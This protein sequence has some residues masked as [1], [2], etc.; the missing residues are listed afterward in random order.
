MAQTFKE[1]AHLRGNKEAFDKG[2]ESI[3]GKKEEK[4]HECMECKGDGKSTETE[5]GRCPVCEGRG[6]LK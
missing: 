5:D 1:T 4:F 6:V 3:F 2:Y